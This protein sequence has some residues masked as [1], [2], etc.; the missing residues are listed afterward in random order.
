MLT[1]ILLILVVSIFVINRW[2]I[3]LI[4]NVKIAFSSSAYFYYC[5]FF[6]LLPIFGGLVLCYVIVGTRFMEL[7]CFLLIHSTFHLCVMWIWVLSYNLVVW[8]I[9]LVIVFQ[10]TL[11][12][13]NP[14]QW[15]GQIRCRWRRKIDVKCI[16]CTCQHTWDLQSAF[17]LKRGFG[18]Y[19]LCRFFK[20]FIRYRPILRI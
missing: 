16:F 4:T 3:S 9:S 11:F 20:K 8:Q 17:C 7:T 13:P 14:S 2:W 15:L 10:I 6:Y 12:F 19:H 1:L 5:C 18:E